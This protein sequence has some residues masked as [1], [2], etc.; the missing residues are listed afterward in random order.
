MAQNNKKINID[1]I[2]VVKEHDGKYAYERVDIAKSEVLLTDLEAMYKNPNRTVLEMQ[3]YF[4]S[5]FG[6]KQKKY[7]NCC[8][9]YD[10]GLSYIGYVSLPNMITL[11][12]YQQEKQEIIENTRKEFEELIKKSQHAINISKK[13][14]ETEENNRISNWSTNLKEK[15]YRVAMRY[16]HAVD[17]LVA[18][19]SIKK[20][21][22]VRMLSHEHIGWTTIRHNISDDL[23]ITIDT[24]FGYGTSSYFLLN[25]RYKGIDL[26]PYSTLVKYY[27]VGV[28]EIKKCTRSYRP[29]RENWALAMDFVADVGNKT[30]NGELSFVR[31][32]LKEE[33]NEMISRLYSISHNPIGVMEDIKC[34]PIELGGLRKVYTMDGDDVKMLEIYPEEM[35]I[36]FK[37]SKLSSALDLIEKLR[38][39]SEVYE[40]ALDAVV[41][42]E[43][44]NRLLVP[45][46]EEWIVKISNTLAELDSELKPSEEQQ[47]LISEEIKNHEVKIR[48]LYDE[49]KVNN[50]SWK[51]VYEEYLKCNPELAVLENEKKLLDNK[52]YNLKTDIRK[53]K[54]FLSTLHSCFE[55]IK[56]EGLLSA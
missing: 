32:W 45:E 39:S 31:N 25:V 27:Y 21:S 50:V 22:Q 5:H 8:L 41:Q 16:I 55:R 12:Q 44:I 29:D 47:R 34:R 1:Y 3:D 28:A 33:I 49:Q 30:K 15:F 51:Q 52:I 23:T 26:L 4:I 35:G 40:P 53:R 42:I 38:A 37:A 2:G 17:Y 18:T 7:Y 6:V 13:C 24:N 54:E 11:E 46:L 10:Y 56:V 20:D 48:V 9:P 43:D 36:I 14:I 19:E